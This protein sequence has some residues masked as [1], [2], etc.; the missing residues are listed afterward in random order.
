MGVI[1]ARCST[2]HARGD[3]KNLLYLGTLASSAKSTVQCQTVM[4]PA[5]WSLW[6]TETEGSGTIQNSRRKMTNRWAL[7]HVKYER[8][9]NKLKDPTA[10]KGHLI[11][12]YRYV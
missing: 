12:S 4:A 9:K 7:R 6:G 11:S 8:K 3:S 2:V 1:S 5:I 10:L